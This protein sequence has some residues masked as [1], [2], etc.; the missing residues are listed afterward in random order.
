MEA[1]RSLLLSDMKGVAQTT[2]IRGVALSPVLQEYGTQ[3]P[4]RLYIPH[5]DI[6]CCT[7]A[8]LLWFSRQRLTD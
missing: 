4:I 1:G 2:P 5:G 7:D 3:G 6:L 8:V